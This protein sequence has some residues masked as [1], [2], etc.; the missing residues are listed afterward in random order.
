AAGRGAVRDAA[1]AGHLQDQ[2]GGGPDRGHAGATTAGGGGPERRGAAPLSGHRPARQRQTR[3]AG[4]SAIR[5][6]SPRLRGAGSRP[7]SI[8]ITVQSFL[9][10]QRRAAIARPP[11]MVKMAKEDGAGGGG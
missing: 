7:S 1:A 9:L 5:L 3:G 10:S 8:C 2:R 6:S 11:L 4:P